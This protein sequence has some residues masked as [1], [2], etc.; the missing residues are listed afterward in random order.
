MD[1]EQILENKPLVFGI[2]GGAILVLFV[3]VIVLA[4]RPAMPVSGSVDGQKNPI[5][6]EK[7]IKNLCFC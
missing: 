1:F 5:V 6:R 4:T 7:I 3:M 2:I